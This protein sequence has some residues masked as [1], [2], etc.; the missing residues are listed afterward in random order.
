MGCCHDRGGRDIEPG[1]CPDDAPCFLPGRGDLRGRGQIGC[2][3]C[4]E[5]FDHAY[6]VAIRRQA[7]VGD[8]SCRQARHHQTRPACLARVPLNQ[9]GHVGSVRI[10]RPKIDCG[11]I[12]KPSG[13]NV[14][15]RR[16][17]AIELPYGVA[18]QPVMHV[19]RVACGSEQQAQDQVACRRGVGQEW[20]CLP[21]L[22][23][24][25]RNRCENG[26]AVRVQRRPAAFLVLDERQ[27]GVQD[28][29]FCG[30]RLGGG[31]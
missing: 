25:Q 29:T 20:V 5:I 9:S 10:P 4:A 6:K 17:G 15:C 24:Q 8:V 11:S 26:D 14:G 31:D 18:C 21:V 28:V 27:K 7:Q 30:V 1:S 12:R 13:S 2:R 19:S 16:I 23:H 22:T 3:S